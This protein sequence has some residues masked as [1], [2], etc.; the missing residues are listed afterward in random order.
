MRRQPW[1]S[2]LHRTRPCFAAECAWLSRVEKER[3]N[4]DSALWHEG[5]RKVGS[6]SGAEGVPRAARELV[7]PP[8]LPFTSPALEHPPRNAP[9]TFG[10]IDRLLFKLHT[11]FWGT[12]YSYIDKAAVVSTWSSSV[13]C[14]TP[15]SLL[16]ARRAT[17]IDKPMNP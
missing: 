17:R 8:T 16:A 13:S 14:W 6:A 15:S 11:L 9:W 4:D 3:W 7:A 12:I 2:C 1:P 5:F 10:N